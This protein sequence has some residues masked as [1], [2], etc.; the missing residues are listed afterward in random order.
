MLDDYF[1][2]PPKTKSVVA[3]VSSI[4][5]T[6]D[7]I[8]I[9][10]VGVCFGVDL[11][12]GW[13]AMAFT[14][15]A[16]VAFTNALNF[17][18]GLDGLAGG[19]SVVILSSFLY[20]GYSHDD[21]LMI[22]LSG[23]FMTAILGFLIFNWNPASIFMGDSGSLVLGFV[24]SLLG[25]KAIA[26]VPAV[27]ILFLAAIPIIDTTVV[28]TRRLKSGRSILEADKC[29]I[30]HHL[31]SFFGGNVKKSVTLLILAQALFTSMGL[32]FIEVSDGAFPLILFGIITYVVIRVVSRVYKIN[33]N[34][35]QEERIKHESI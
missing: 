7:G 4:M 3:V 22:I 8:I 32:L 21:L 1:N 17:I 27:T 25:I 13:L 26:Y 9:D 28:V 20:I 2:M 14:I 15:F 10:H 35:L 23:S 34:T 12:L 31:K 24:I 5:L 30:H 16:V 33:Q 6:Y 18:D 11:S 19:I 29:H